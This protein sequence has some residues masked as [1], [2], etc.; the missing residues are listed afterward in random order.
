[1]IERNSKRKFCLDITGGFPIVDDQD[2]KLCADRGGTIGTRPDDN[3][4]KFV[5]R[6][7]EFM[8]RTQPVI[9]KYQSQGIVHEI[10]G[11]GSIEEVHQRVADTIAKLA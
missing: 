5:T 8:N 4:E 2:A 10:D 3:P 9:A 6:W 7:N 11:M 1:M